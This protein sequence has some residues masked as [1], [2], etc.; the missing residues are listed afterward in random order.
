MVQIVEGR[1]TLETAPGH[2]FTFDSLKDLHTRALMAGIPTNATLT[3]I[4]WHFRPDLQAPQQVSVYYRVDTE[5]FPRFPESPPP[6]QAAPLAA[7]PQFPNPITT[8]E[9]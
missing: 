3:R 9:K 4:A 8:Q 7:P 6:P 2:H 1:V 5:A